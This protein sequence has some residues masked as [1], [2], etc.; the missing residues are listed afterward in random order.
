MW[1]AAINE[2]GAR[3]VL[4]ATE[5]P[6]SEV[7]LPDFGFD[8]IASGIFA[9]KQEAEIGLLTLKRPDW[10]RTVDPQFAELIRAQLK[11]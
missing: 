10:E 7:T 3:V 6:N 2:V 5:V 4:P 8:P 11:R 9:T 1:C